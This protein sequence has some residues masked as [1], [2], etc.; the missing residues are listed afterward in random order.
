MTKIL[1]SLF[2]TA[3]YLFFNCTSESSVEPNTDEIVIQAYIYAGESVTDVRITST[4]PLGTDELSAPPIND[5]EV[6]LIKDGIR[7][8]LQSS[9]GDSGYYHYEGSDLSLNEG[10]AVRIEVNYSDKLAYGETVIPPPPEGIHASSD[11]IIYPTELTWEWRYS[12]EFEK[13][14][15]MLYWDGDGESLYF[16]VIETVDPNPQPVDTTIFPFRGIFRIRTR[17]STADSLRLNFMQFEYLGRHRAK[18][19]MVNQEYADLYQTQS[20]DSRDLNEP[21]TNIV[22]GLGVFSAFNSDSV[23]FEVKY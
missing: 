23:F 9:P 17:P 4:L 15:M 2:L 7:Y 6:T 21:L 1:F 13:S 14:Q 18:I 12:E 5:A 22:N 20:Q 11:E 10:D 16:A 3:T 19:Y 8:T